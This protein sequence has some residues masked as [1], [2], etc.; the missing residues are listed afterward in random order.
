MKRFAVIAAF[1]AVLSV[2][3]TALADTPSMEYTGWGNNKATTTGAGEYSTVLIKNS[4]GNIVYINQAESSFDGSVNF[5]MKANPVCGNYTV[6]F[7]NKNGDNTSTAFSVGVVA[8][9]DNDVPMMRLSSMEKDGKNS[10]GFYTIVSGTDYSKFKS[11]KVGYN[12]GS[13]TI[14]GGFDLKDGN[15]TVFSEES[16]LIL[17]FELDEIEDNELDSVSVFLSNDTVG[18]EN[19]YKGGSSQ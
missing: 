12:N 4:I 3:V 8:D 14:Y 13:E 5:M 19:A 1:A 15:D 18:S 6:K 7:G 10:A 16:D 17:I 11:L 9:K 2:G